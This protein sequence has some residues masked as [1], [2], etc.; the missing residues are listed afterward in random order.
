[1]YAVYLQYLK[2]ELSYEAYILHADKHESLSQVDS[3]VF[4]GFGQTCSK[5][6]GKFAVS[7]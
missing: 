1:M 4:Y 5:Y 3:I 6:L 2:K 7:L